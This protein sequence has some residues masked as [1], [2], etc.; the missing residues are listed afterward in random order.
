M[1]YENRIRQL[2]HLLQ[3]IDN[4]IYAMEK[5]PPGV[6]EAL[7]DDLKKQRLAYRDELSRLRKQQYEQSQTVIF[8]DDR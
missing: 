5:N 3:D 8:D 1:T 6:Q 7:L 4:K 2:E